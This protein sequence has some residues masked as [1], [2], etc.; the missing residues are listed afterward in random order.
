MTSRSRF[1]LLALACAILFLGVI[2]LGDLAGYDDAV[3]ATQAKNVVESGDW[4]SRS[5][6]GKPAVE[7]PPLFVWEQAVFLLMFGISDIAAKAPAAL[8]AIGTVLLTYWLARRF[9]RDSL[10]ASVAMFIMLATPYF[11]KYGSHAMTDVPTTF[12]FVCAV[13]AWLLVERDPR[14]CLAAGAFTAL[15]LLTRGFIG[16]ALPMMFAIDVVVAKRAVPKRYLA[17]AFLIA[18]A[19]LAALYAVLLLKNSDYFVSE[20]K[21]WLSVEVYGAFP[22]WWRRYTGAI[23][24]ALMLLK[25]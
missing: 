15:A 11:I 6:R 14:W 4:L 22:S 16:F 10:D 20:Q 24:Y 7:H 12:L 5:V 17:A 1:L 19:P 3:F 13:G 21:R 2:R 18:V 9:V 23:E 25:S 8:S